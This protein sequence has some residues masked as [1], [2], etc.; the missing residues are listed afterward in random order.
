VGFYFFADLIR[1]EPLLTPSALSATLA[2]PAV[3]QSYLHW[4]ALP[5]S[6]LWF[7]ERLLLLT[8]AH[9]LAFALLGVAAV[10]L[11]RAAALH[12]NPLTGAIFGAVVCSL[13]FFAT[14]SVANDQVVR[15]TPSAASVLLANV[16]AGM[17][18]GAYVRL[19]ERRAA[20]REYSRRSSGSA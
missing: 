4:A 17:A 9:F 10:A 12:M 5:A 6:Y 1:L 3:D 13:V 19:S 8:V 2:F 11:F 20:A 14:Y 18:M 7:G 15:G 16:L